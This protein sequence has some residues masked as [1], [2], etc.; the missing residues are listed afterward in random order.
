MAT[1]DVLGIIMAMAV[2][3]CAVHATPA[4]DRIGARE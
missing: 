4:F 1:D 3:E 2:C